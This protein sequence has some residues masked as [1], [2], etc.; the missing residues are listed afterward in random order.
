MQFGSGITVAVVQASSVALIGPL[1]WEP[2]YAV[3]SVL[4]KEKQKQKQKPSE[5]MQLK[6]LALRPAFIAAEH[7]AGPEELSGQEEEGA[8]G[9]DI[10]LVRTAAKIEATPVTTKQLPF[11]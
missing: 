7:E 3:S 9:L 8:H 5:F 2:P 6:L 11:N 10:S 1:A 4:K